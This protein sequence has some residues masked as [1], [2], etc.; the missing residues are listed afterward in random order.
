MSQKADSYQL[1]DTKKRFRIDIKKRFRTVLNKDVINVRYYTAFDV[2]NFSCE[3]CVAGQNNK[4]RIIHNFDKRKY[5]EIVEA[6]KKLPF[7][8][9]I[10][11]GVGGEFFLS[12][13][14]IEG[15]RRLSWSR[16][17]EHLNLITNLS[18]DY[19]RYADLL[20]GYDR[21]KVAI[22]ASYHPTQTENK[23]RWL[24]T[25]LHINKEYDFAVILVAYPPLLGD[26]P[27]IAR[28]LRQA[29]LDV[30]VQGYIGSYNN[31]VYPLSYTM[32]EKELLK[33][34][35]YS[36][37]DYEFFV[38]CKKP[39]LCNAGY[40]SLYIDRE[41]KVF[42]CGMGKGVKLGNLTESPEIRFFDAPRPCVHE[43]CFCDT[44][45][46]NTVIFE[47]YYFM[48]GGNQ[49]KYAY[50]FKQLS[51]HIKELDEWKIAY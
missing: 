8:M 40:K 35:M 33:D 9:N 14:L 34:I 30:F 31:K 2:C 46:I 49:H 19:A 45:Y 16:N 42:S 1:I 3:Y 47:Q 51:E 5:I 28:E 21:K 7:S 29:G 10:R 48:L 24:E 4:A 38:N 20:R 25:A 39:G 44:E 26:L 27:I 11:I 32:E 37:H 18:F 36:R 50:R 6:I 15:G 22:V 17:V 43:T 13:D 12:P 23:K 41:G